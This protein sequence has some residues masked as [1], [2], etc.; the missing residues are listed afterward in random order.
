[1]LEDFFLLRRNGKGTEI[2]TVGSAGGLGEIEDLYY[3][4]RKAL[5]SL[6]VPFSRLNSDD[7]QNSSQ[8]AITGN[9]IT[10]EELKFSKFVNNLQSHFNYFFFGLLKKHLI[11]KGHI[12]PEDWKGLKRKL[13]FVYKSDSQ[14]ADTKRLNALERRLNVLRDVEDYIGKWF[15]REDVYTKVLGMTTEEIKE[16]ERKLEQ[17]KVKYAKGDRDI[18]D[19]I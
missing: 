3:F 12:Q 19:L 13:K 9:E 5:M 18:E 17:E 4:Q 8:A 1:M 7:R 10:R 2:D 14:F 11:Y 15:T 16:H 6:N